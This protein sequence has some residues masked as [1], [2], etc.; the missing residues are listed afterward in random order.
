VG[1][2]YALTREADDQDAN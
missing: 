2:Y 1:H